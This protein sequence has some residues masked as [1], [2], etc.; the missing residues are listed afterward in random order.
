M[1]PRS[2]LFSFGGY[3]VRC[4]FFFFPSQILCR[5]FHTSEELRYTVASARLN[6]WRCCARSLIS[7]R[8]HHVTD[9]NGKTVL[10][11]V[12]KKKRKKRHVYLI[13]IAIAFVDI[14]V[15]VGTAT[16]LNRRDTTRDSTNGVNL[17]SL[18]SPS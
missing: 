8:E 18:Y 17:P 6:F 10:V 16:F 11:A 14:S 5:I 7:N 12:V 3:F 15:A 2:L 1:I 4:R 13:P 9:A